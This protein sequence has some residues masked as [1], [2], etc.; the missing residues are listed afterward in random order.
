MKHDAVTVERFYTGQSSAL[1]LKLI[2][3]AG[4]LKRVIHEPTINRPG[5]VLTGFTH[6]FANKRLQVI[7]NAEAFYLKSLTERQRLRRC[8]EFF[9]HRM[10][11]VIFSRSLRADNAFLHL[12]ISGSGIPMT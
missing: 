5:L 3:G 4:G 8:R 6:Y 10:P 7:G 11:A 9:Q 12:P 1:E 2:A